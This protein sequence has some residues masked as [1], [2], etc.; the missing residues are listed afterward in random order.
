ML[1][2]SSICTG[3]FSTKWIRM[4][5]MTRHVQEWGLP[6]GTFEGGFQRGD[7]QRVCGARD[8]S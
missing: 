5:L 4:V 8:S 1:S 3:V 7:F 6:R 2:D